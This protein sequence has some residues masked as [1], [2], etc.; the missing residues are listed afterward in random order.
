MNGTAQ[1]LARCA[2]RAVSV[3]AL[4]TLTACASEPTPVADLPVVVIEPTLRL[5]LAVEPPGPVRTVWARLLIEPPD[6]RP[7]T[8]APAGAAGDGPGPRVVI[9]LRVRWQDQR[10]DGPTASGHGGQSV[11]EW[12]GSLVAE[13]GRPAE[14]DVR[15]ELGELNGALARRIDVDGRIIGLELRRED[16]RSGGVVL[17]LPAAHLDSLAPMPAG[18]LESHLQSGSPGGI[19]LLAAGS[20]PSQRDATLDALIAALPGSEGPARGA[21]LAALL[22]LTGETKGRDPQ[23]WRTWWNQ[24]RQQARP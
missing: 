21:I 9:E 10:G 23:L 8:V 22:Y 16:A 20:P 18:S 15:L 14:I 2:L 6:E 17:K 4:S 12:T 13:R 1:R 5:E 19:F 24:Q 7:L 3:V 11:L